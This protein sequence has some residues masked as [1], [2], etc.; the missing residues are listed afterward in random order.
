MVN[1]KQNGTDASFRPKTGNESRSLAITF[2]FFHKRLLKLKLKLC[3]NVTTNGNTMNKK[4]LG[5]NIT[6]NVLR[7]LAALNIHKH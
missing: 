1:H 4:T 2:T 3:I 7:V 6:Q 5:I